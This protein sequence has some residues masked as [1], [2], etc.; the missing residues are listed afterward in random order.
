LKRGGVGAPIAEVYV[1]RDRH[2]VGG[3]I[4]RQVSIT[5]KGASVVELELRVFIYLGL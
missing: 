5:A 3:F 1:T 2:H 4:P